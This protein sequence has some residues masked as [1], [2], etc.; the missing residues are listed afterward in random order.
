MEIKIQLEILLHYALKN[1]LL[2]PEDYYFARNNLMALLKIDAIC[3][4]NVE[5]SDNKS[6]AEI[7]E[8]ILNY[9][10]ESRIIEDNTVTCRDKL[11][12]QIMGLLIARPSEIIRKFNAIAENGDI[13][14]ATDW[15]YDF[16]QKTNYILTDRIAKN[17]SWKTN[18]EFGNIEVTINLSKPEKDPKEIAAALRYKSSGYP[19]CILCAENEGYKGD[20]NLP[21]RQN[22]RIIPMQLLGEKWFLQYS[23]YVYFNEHCIVLSDEHRPMQISKD[24]FL[25]LLKLVEQFPHYFIGSNA[26]LPI[27]GGSILS[28]DHF[29]G[30]RHD[31]PMAN[32]VVEHYFDNKFGQ[33]DAGIVKWPMSVIR[34][35][36]QSINDLVEFSEIIYQNWKSYSNPELNI[37]SHTDSVP[38]NTITPIARFKDDK[39]ELDLVLRNNRT[40]EEFPDG[41]FHPH[42]NLHHIKKENIGLI[43]VMGLAILPGRLLGELNLIE[44]HFNSDSNVLEICENHLSLQKHKDWIKYLKNKY[45]K[46]QYS[47]TS[48]ILRKEV[49]Y[50]F[51]DVLGDSGV[52]KRTDSGKKAFI[53]FVNNLKY[54]L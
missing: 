36:S 11:D 33:V 16:S 2:G 14:A 50:K 53:E 46:I 3:E 31:F 7:L 24:T 1:N 4:E 30:G 25:R 35:Q 34:L 44:Q 21:A 29:Q 37:F 27:V 6:I 32:S 23:P 19:K 9:A 49:T 17:I 45:P 39:Y 8:P 43:E 10:Y 5:F 26:D 38:H 20:A 52:F 48:E 41:I 42:Q 12:A 40:T 54:E 13:K 51:L 22:H 15:Y 18:T 47:E 28:H